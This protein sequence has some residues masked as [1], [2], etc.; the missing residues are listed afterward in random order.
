MTVS[1]SFM[2]ENPERLPHRKTLRY[3]FPP[4]IWIT[5]CRNVLLK[6]GTN[7][8]FYFIPFLLSTLFKN[9]TE[10]AFITLSVLYYTLDLEESSR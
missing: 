6:A 8:L 9:A 4:H 1:V 5:M 10:I 2:S 7:L 3:D